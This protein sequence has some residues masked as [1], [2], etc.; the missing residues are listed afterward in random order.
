[1]T[2]FWICNIRCNYCGKEVQT[3]G[4]IP[5]NWRQGLADFI[6]LHSDLLDKEEFHCCDD[7]KC[8]AEFDLHKEH[9]RT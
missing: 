9:K 5:K 8:I 3:N 1:M 6:N 2:R 4:G 7:L